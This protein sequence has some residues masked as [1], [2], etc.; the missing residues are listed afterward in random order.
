M[1]GTSG[2][3]PMDQPASGPD[4]TVRMYRTDTRDLQLDPERIIET[5]EALHGR[6][7][8]RFPGSGLGSLASRVRGIAMASVE[9]LEEVRRPNLPL[10]IGVGIFVLA[11]LGMI[12]AVILRADLPAGIPDL[13][14]FV[15]TLEAGLNELVL[16]GIALFFLF[17]LENRIKRKRALHFLRELRALA[18]I[19]DMHQLTKDPHRLPREGSD[20]PSSP[21]R[22][23]SRF[24][25][26]RYLDYCSETLSL[27]S[28]LAALYAQSFDDPVVLAAVDEVEGLT[29]GLS[30]KIW[31]KIMILDQEMSHAET[32]SGRIGD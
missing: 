9:R 31:Q 5:V 6:I 22:G 3:R 1:T 14:E 16:I 29:T 24:E 4:P 25:L 20:T 12:F 26:T 17:T 19:V 11:L 21:K 15:Q 23:L 18:H 7:E 27:V 8:E 2:R 28:K 30:A 13:F 32:S 10:R